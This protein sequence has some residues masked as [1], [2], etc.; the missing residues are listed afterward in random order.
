[1]LSLFVPQFLCHRH[2]RLMGNG[3]ITSLDQY[4]RIKQSGHII[5]VDVV[6][7]TFF[8]HRGQTKQYS[9]SVILLLFLFFFVP[10]FV[11][12]HSMM[13]N[14]KHSHEA[15][16]EHSAYYYQCCHSSLSSSIIRLILVSSSLMQAKMNTASPARKHSNMSVILPSPSRQT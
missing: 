1:M 2:H 16:K 8:R 6:T 5:S 7:R 13:V 4:T 11:I 12:R 15:R 14:E 10:L 9:I 3:S